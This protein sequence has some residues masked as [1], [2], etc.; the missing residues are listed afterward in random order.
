MTVMSDLRNKIRKAGVELDKLKDMDKND[1]KKLQGIL[2]KIDEGMCDLSPRRDQLEKL[3]L[4][5][6]TLE[7]EVKDYNRDQ[8]SLKDNASGLSTLI[9]EQT[10]KYP[11]M[12]DTYK[13][14]NTFALQLDKLSDL[15][16]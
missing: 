9:K 10:K 5:Q 7:D 4:K 6:E 15:K 1:K 8:G 11:K 14:L 16:M 13:D 12:G 3:I 2:D